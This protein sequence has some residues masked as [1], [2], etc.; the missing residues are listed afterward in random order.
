MNAR[1]IHD[2]LGI[3]GMLFLKNKPKTKSRAKYAM[4]KLVVMVSRYIAGYLNYTLL[5]SFEKITSFSL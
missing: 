3:L 1:D 5:I 4:H 2:L